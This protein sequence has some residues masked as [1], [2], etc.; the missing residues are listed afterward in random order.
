MGRDLIAYKNYW[1]PPRK[2][3]IR[4]EKGSQG[5]NVGEKIK[6]PVMG[7]SLG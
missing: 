3:Q 6:D 7:F 2:A 4:Q 5:K 1:L